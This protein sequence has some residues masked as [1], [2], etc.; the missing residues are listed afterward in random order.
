[1]PRITFIQA[2]GLQRQLEVTNEHQTIMEFALAN[3]IG[4]I[5]ADCGGRTVCGTCHCFV[6]DTGVFG[7]I[8]ANE[9]AML[10]IR[11]DRA[12]NSRLSCQL[13][14]ADVFTDITIELPEFQM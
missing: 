7:A 9:E 14:L 11:P 4:G 5:D 3:G 1:M 13:S 10:D 8:E 2:D 6:T 12:P